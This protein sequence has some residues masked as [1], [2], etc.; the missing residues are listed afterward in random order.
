M[1]F[2]SLGKFTRIHNWEQD[3]IDDIDIVTDHH[4]EEDDN[5]AQA[6]NECFLRNGSVAMKGNFDA[7][8]FKVVGVADAVSS[9]DAVN[10]LQLENTRTEIVTSINNNVLVGDLKCSALQSDHKNWML[11]DGRAILRKDYEELF[12]AIGTTFGKG[13]NSTTFNIPDCR[14]VVVR[15]VDNGRGLDAKRVL[16][17]YQ[18]DA[19]PNIVGKFRAHRFYEVFSGAIYQLVNHAQSNFAGGNGI[20]GQN[21]RT[22][23]FDASKS[24]SVYGRDSVNEIRVKNIALNYFIKVKGE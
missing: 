1:P 7:G 13:D 23:G 3:R 20:G 10:K 19:A 4:D 5:F 21:D 24:S 15:G 2:D 6:F 8:G 14:G 12:D 11:C 18:R 17:S 16:G 9:K 22:I